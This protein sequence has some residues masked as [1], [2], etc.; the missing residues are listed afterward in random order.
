MSGPDENHGC[1]WWNMQY[2]ILFET[3]RMH[4]Y[5]IITNM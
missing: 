5:N 4:L 1:A 3:E 2:W